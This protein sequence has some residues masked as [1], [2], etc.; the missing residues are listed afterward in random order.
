MKWIHIG[1]LS[2]LTGSKEHSSGPQKVQP[3]IKVTLY[4]AIP[5]V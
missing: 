2:V 3:I 5:V 4:A 1:E